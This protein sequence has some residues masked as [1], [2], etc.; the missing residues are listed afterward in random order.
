M[1]RQRGKKFPWRNP[2]LVESGNKALDNS[3][4]I[5]QNRIDVYNLYNCSNFCTKWRHN[6]AY[7]QEITVKIS[8]KHAALIL[9]CWLHLYTWTMVSGCSTVLW[10]HTIPWIS[11]IKLI[12]VC[13]QYWWQKN[14]HQ[15]LFQLW[16]HSNN[17]LIISR[18]LYYLHIFCSVNT[19]VTNTATRAQ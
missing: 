7:Y 11:V 16:H 5:W 8:P 2:K 1:Q 14:I 17:E 19:G 4:H 12:N 10:W 6:A 18:Y 3:M 9:N 15:K 13:L